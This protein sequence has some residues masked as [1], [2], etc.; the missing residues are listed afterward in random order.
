MQHRIFSSLANFIKKWITYFF[1]L[2]TI[3]VTVLSVA[4]YFGKLNVYLEIIANFK[5]QYLLIAFCTFIFFTLNRQKIWW[6]ASFF[7]LLIN[8]TE[9]A[10]WY[11]PQL[12]VNHQSSGQSMRLFL[13]NVLFSNTRYAD[14]ISLVREEKPAIAVFLEATRPWTEELKVLQD[15]LPYHISAEKLEIEVYSSLPL[16]NTSIQL[17]GEKRG[18]VISDLTIQGK[19]VSIIASHANPQLVFGS[20]GYEW[21][22]K[23]L[24]EGIGNYVAQLIKPVVL[25]GDL[26]A[27]MW[28]PYYK[29]MIQRSGLHN[30]RAGFGILPTFGP[31]LPWVGVPIDHC[32]VSPD[33]QVLNTRTG[34]DVGSDHLPLITDLVIPVS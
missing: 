17:Y 10:P 8:F 21:R 22:N 11:L 32:L 30:T 1:I 31:F 29:S 34:K 13:S 3:I 9:V 26:N 5:F 16:E 2:M 15:I 18:N 33:I 20:Q 24:E 6:L 27:T 4:G 14:V 7:C 23:H 28:S 25:I 12:G 19:V